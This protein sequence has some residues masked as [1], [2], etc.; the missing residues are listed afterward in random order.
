MLLAAVPT[1]MAK[2]QRKPKHVPQD[3]EWYWSKQR[4]QWE[5]RAD[6]ELARGESVVI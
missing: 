3:Q 1:H 6:E 4:Q 5:R 2:Q